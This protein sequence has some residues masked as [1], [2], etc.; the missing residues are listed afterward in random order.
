MVIDARVDFHV[1]GFSIGTRHAFSLIAAPSYVE[2]QKARTSL[3]T[4]R[5][6]DLAGIIQRCGLGL[7]RVTT[8]TA[9]AARSNGTS[10]TVTVMRTLTTPRGAWADLIRRQK[11]VALIRRPAV[12]LDQAA[13]TGAAERLK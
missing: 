10:L 6:N 3:S 13:D 2:F 5:F 1:V 4:K 7:N 11:L 8:S 9:R 12:E